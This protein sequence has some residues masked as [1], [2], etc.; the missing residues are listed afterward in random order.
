MGIHYSFAHHQMV[1]TYVCQESSIRRAQAVC[2]RVPGAVVDQAI[3]TLLLELMQPMTL[4]IALAVQ[5][6]VEARITET[7]TLRRKQIERAQYEAELARRRFIK[8]DP[9][10]RLVAQVG[11]LAEL[12]EQAAVD[13]VARYRLPLRV[14]VVGD[15]SAK[16]LPPR[17]PVQTI[18]RVL[19]RPT[20]DC[21]S[22]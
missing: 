4:E 9:D 21:L 3:G 7:D 22:H 20:R 13:P 6:E 14:I 17:K 10:H 1:P 19:C 12:F 11:V 8:V 16:R 15:L 18:Q 5:Q 2:Q